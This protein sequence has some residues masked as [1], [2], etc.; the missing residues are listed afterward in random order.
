MVSRQK[1][2]RT[3]IEAGSFFCVALKPQADCVFIHENLPSLEAAK[4]LLSGG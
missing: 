4:I 2:V 1:L 3:C